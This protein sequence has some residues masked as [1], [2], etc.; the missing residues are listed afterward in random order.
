MVGPTVS[1]GTVAQIGIVVRDLQKT[2]EEYWNIFGVGPWSIWKYD[3]TV[4]ADMTYQGKP[5]EYGWTI[6]LAQVGPV[7]WEVI[8]PLWGRVFTRSFFE[9]AEKVCTMSPTWWMAPGR[10]LKISK[11]SGW[12]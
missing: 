7:Q 6:A 1:L 10:S 8:E 2:I 4:V 11:Q 3:P 12:T 9:R 5:H